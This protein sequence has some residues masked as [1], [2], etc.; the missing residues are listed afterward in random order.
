MIGLERNEILVLNVWKD[1]V[2]YRWEFF[3]FSVVGMWVKFFICLIMFIVFIY[4]IL[5]VFFSC[6]NKNVFR[7]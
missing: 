5:L 6:G 7:N 2:W 3:S 4:I 1:L